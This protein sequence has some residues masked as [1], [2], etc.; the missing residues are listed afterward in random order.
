MTKSPEEGC[1]RVS[2]S[3]YRQATRSRGSI[4]EAEEIGRQ[5]AREP[6]P[7]SSSV[8]EGEGIFMTLGRVVYAGDMY[9]IRW[10][11]SC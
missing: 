11:S 1:I 2:S 9:L 6:S 8:Q 7:E 4:L 10:T 3:I 5:V